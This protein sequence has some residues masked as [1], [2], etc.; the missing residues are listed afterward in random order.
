MLY[1]MDYNHIKKEIE[2]WEPDQSAE[3]ALARLE[4]EQAIAIGTVPTKSE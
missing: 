1:T 3:H 2:R 4:A